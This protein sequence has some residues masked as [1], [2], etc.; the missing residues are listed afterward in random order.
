MNAHKAVF[1]LFYLILTLQM[2]YKVS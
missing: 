1:G 2:M